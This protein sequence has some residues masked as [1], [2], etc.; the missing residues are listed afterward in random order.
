MNTKK[1]ILQKHKDQNPKPT[2]PMNNQHTQNALANQK[3]QRC[4]FQ[5]CQN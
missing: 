1:D 5:R 3:K 4:L 2:S